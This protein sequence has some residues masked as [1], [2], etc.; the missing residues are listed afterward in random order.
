MRSPKGACL[1]FLTVALVAPFF[2]VLPRLVLYR[3]R[4]AYKK[5]GDKAKA[6][7]AIQHGL[8]LNPDSPWVKSA[9]KSLN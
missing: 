9:A 5:Q 2:F 6:R 4:K 1:L 8:I 7:D 3:Q